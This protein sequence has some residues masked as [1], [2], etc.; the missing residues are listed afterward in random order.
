MSPFFFFFF[1]LE[2]PQA[3]NSSPSDTTKPHS[4][5]ARKMAKESSVSLPLPP[6]ASTRRSATVPLRTCCSR[7]FLDSDDMVCTGNKKERGGTER[8]KKHCF[9]FRGI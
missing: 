6:A 8:E 2:Q 3:P 4:G 7:L 1:Q 5:S 9:A